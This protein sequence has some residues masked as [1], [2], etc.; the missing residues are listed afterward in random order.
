MRGRSNPC[1]LYNAVL[2]LRCLVHGDGCANAGSL[3][4]LAW[5]RT[6]LEE[7]FDMKTTIVGHRNS[8]DVASE[9]NIL[10]RTI[11]AKSAGWEYE[12]DQGHVEVMIEELE[13]TS[14]K[15]MSTPG[16][17]EA[18][19]KS[20]VGATIVDDDPDSVPLVGVSDSLQSTCGSLQL[21][22][23]RSS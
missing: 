8:A 10:N 5:L 2:D 3:D 16:V 6:E 15:S 14:L 18:V 22:C 9:G 12:C 11:R 23:R 21:Y 19:D 1:V 7:E 20:Q 17:A 4:N 13:L